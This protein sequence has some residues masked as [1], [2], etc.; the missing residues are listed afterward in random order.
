M[1][2]SS[3]QVGRP[4]PLPTLTKVHA[5]LT[6]CC[7]EL[8]LLQVVAVLWGWALFWKVGGG[9]AAVLAALAQGPSS[10]LTAIRPQAAAAGSLGLAF[11]IC[12]VLSPPLSLCLVF[13]FSV[14]L[15]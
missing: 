11:P 6:G 12:R 9:G 14:S 4:L 3:L 15:I 10:H 8:L 2:V 5:N 1:L 7:L 13:F